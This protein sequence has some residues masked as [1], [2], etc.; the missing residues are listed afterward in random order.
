[1]GFDDP[2][3]EVIVTQNNNVNNK[4]NGKTWM[5]FD[6]TEGGDGTETG[7][8]LWRDNQTGEITFVPINLT[9]AM[10]EA[11]LTKLE[12]S[13]ITITEENVSQSLVPAGS[14]NTTISEN[15]DNGTDNNR[16]TNPTGYGD[17]GDGWTS[18]GDRSDRNK[19][20][21]SGSLL[22]DDIIAEY[23]VKQSKP[24]KDIIDLVESGYV[25]PKSGGSGGSGGKTQTHIWHKPFKD[26]TNINL[27]Y[28]DSEKGIH[29]NHGPDPIGYGVMPPNQHIN[30][31]K[32][33]IDFSSSDIYDIT[34]GSS[35]RGSGNND[36][37]ISSDIYMD[38]GLSTIESDD[39]GD[40]RKYDIYGQLIGDKN[41]KNDNNQSSNPWY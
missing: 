32:E 17:M 39:K 4:N 37:T 29:V 30:P 1:M 27:L 6:Q 22:G 20:G 3:E 33:S 35:G 15:G 41:K 8:N 40:K 24:D 38:L 7:G 28:S 14:F 36:E 12:E 18:T 19:G 26:P 16:N 21:D 23:M 13:G 5:G 2:P 25:E 9:E 34:L 31:K 10:T 11:D